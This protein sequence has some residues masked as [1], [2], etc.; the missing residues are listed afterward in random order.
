METTY[1]DSIHKNH[2]SIIL[3]DNIKQIILFGVIIQ[4]IYYHILWLI[5]VIFRLNY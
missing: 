2:L 5:Q 1:L 4:R 3:L